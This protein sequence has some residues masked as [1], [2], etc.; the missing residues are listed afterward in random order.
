MG[1]AEINHNFAARLLSPGVHYCIATDGSVRKIDHTHV[2][3][4]GFVL[5]RGRSASHAEVRILGT[6]RCA[7]DAEVTALT[8]AF[9]H[10]RSLPSPDSLWVLSDCQSAIRSLER[11]RPA[12]AAECAL[13]EAISR[14]CSYHPRT[15]VDIT[16]CPSH[17]GV[18]PNELIDSLLG[19]MTGGA[20]INCILTSLPLM[21][22]STPSVRGAVEKKL[23][24][25]ESRWLPVLA[26]RCRSSSAHTIAL[27]DAPRDTVRQWMSILRHNREAQCA[28]LGLAS[29][30][31]C[32]WRGTQLICPSFNIPLTVTHL[33][34]QCP[35]MLDDRRD[36]L[37]YLNQT[38]PLTPEM[39]RA[40][41]RIL[42]T[43]VLAILPTLR[44]VLRAATETARSNPG[45]P[46]APT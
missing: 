32:F 9:V 10:A 21:P 46:Q 37:T 13:T 36:T 22:A 35:E 1:T 44:T 33:L 45:N 39:L 27:L 23:E 14:F 11:W 4:A 38:P 2:S 7:Y 17:C 26:E 29:N 41:K 31:A 19:R 42:P 6:G 40:D 8:L 24:Q 12:S 5:F 25:D 3:A 30:S 34:L 43:L 20:T 15:V 16:H 18:E 28:V